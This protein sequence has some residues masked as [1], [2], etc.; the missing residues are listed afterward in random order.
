MDADKTVEIKLNPL[1]MDKED[2]RDQ[3]ERLPVLRRVPLRRVKDATREMERPV[4]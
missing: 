4:F 3:R 1:E 2:E